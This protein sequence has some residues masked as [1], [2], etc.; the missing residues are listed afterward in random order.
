MDGY[1]EYVYNTEN[2]SPVDEIW[3]R[4]QLSGCCVIVT[5]REMKTGELRDPSD[6][7][8]EVNGF[9]DEH[10]KEFARR[11]LEG[12]GNVQKFFIYLREKSLKDLAE[13]P[14][15]LLILCLLWKEKDRKALPTK[16]VHIFTQFVETL[17]DHMREKQS[18]GSVFM[19]E[20]YT[21]ELYALGRLAFEALL[22][23]CL[24]FPFSKLPEHELIERLIEVGLFQVSNM[25][26]LKPEKGVYFIHKSVQEY[27]AASFLKEELISNKSE[28]NSLLKVDSIENIFKMREC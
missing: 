19:K 23:D 26:S 24:Y 8:F 25:S 20:D 12:K 14:L 3:K 10:Q 21:A 22:Q 4:N 17:F 16:R 9:D 2:Q 7:Q 15:L 11:F 6:A 1:D 27:L 18:A 13:I 5:S 28:K